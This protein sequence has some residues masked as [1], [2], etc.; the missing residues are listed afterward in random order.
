MFKWI[1]QLFKTDNSYYAGL[2]FT[3]G[4]REALPCAAMQSEIIANELV[5]EKQSF[6]EPVN[7]IVESLKE[8][9][10]WTCEHHV[11]RYL[12]SGFYTKDSKT[13]VSFTT[14]TYPFPYTNC[15][16]LSREENKHLSSE[17]VAFC[18]EKY[19]A[20]KNKSIKEKQDE[21]VSLYKKAAN[22]N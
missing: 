4:R 16:W 1:K 19:E 15:D 7:L 8:E 14:Y 12:G 3:E 18:L 2:P 21:M 11:D 20:A 5:G 10:R 22:E 9:G 6:S 13:G 17:L